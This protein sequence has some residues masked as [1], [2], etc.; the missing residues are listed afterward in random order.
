MHTKGKEH[1]RMQGGEATGKPRREASEET[2]LPAPWSWT[3]SLHHPEEINFYWLSH[4]LWGILVGQPEQTDSTA[5]RTCRLWR[6]PLLHHWR[7]KRKARSYRRRSN[8]RRGKTCRRRK[9]MF[10][11]IYS[12]PPY[13]IVTAENSS[14]NPRLTM[15]GWSLP[16]YRTQPHVSCTWILPSSPPA[17]KPWGP[18][19]QQQPWWLPSPEIKPKAKFFI[20]LKNKS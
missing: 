11:S 18:V 5:V 1:V 9:A 10:L 3:S 4:S 13:K 16:R 20:F 7:R 17:L 15:E 8:R 14:H 12:G 19:P 2:P 6:G